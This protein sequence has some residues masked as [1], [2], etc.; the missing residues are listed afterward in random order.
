[1]SRVKEFF[2]EY[3]ILISQ[4][5]LA[6]IFDILGLLAGF[7]AAL[8]LLDAKQSWVIML[9]PGILGVRGAI[10]G[11][12]SGRL[13]TALHLGRVKP[14][15]R[16][17]TYYYYLLV[18][19]IFLMPV[20]GGVLLGLSMAFVL[21]VFYNASILE[22]LTL[23]I[24]TVSSI[25]L[26][27]VL[28][29]PIASKI[30]F[31]AFKRGLDP[32]VILYP[33]MSTISDVGATLIYAFIIKQFQIFTIMIF[34]VSMIALFISYRKFKD[35]KEFI[36]SVKQS[37]YAIIWLLIFENVAGAFLHS[38][39]SRLKDFSLIMTLY[40]V[41]IDSLGDMGSIIGSRLTT[42]IAIGHVSIGKELFTDYS[43]DLLAITLTAFIF[44]S[45]IG[46]MMIVCGNFF[47]IIIIASAIA[48]ALMT[49]IALF[50][51]IIMHNHGLDP[52]NFVNPVV[53]S[54]ADSIMTL[55]LW[56]A[57]IILSP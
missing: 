21:V 40:P 18:A 53:S 8:F 51:A 24:I 35:N 16:K 42:H 52:D 5:A 20:I 31:T 39:S 32:D 46:L 12:F 6:F 17:N 57:A 47:L 13:S 55:G 56:L 34:I 54:M 22:A 14:S 1:M 19:F 36:E 10:S 37:M 3:N 2:E 43:G 38:V 27:T 26:S 48:I 28:L 11:I 9:Y 25:F 30:A 23:P 45:T 15:L 7:I 4:T 29:V 50:T 41:L 33:I 49:P 44:Y